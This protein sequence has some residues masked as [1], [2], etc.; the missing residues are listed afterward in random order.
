MAEDVEI[1][2]VG[3]LPKKVLIPLAVGLAGF[4][5][6]RFW[7]ARSGT[8]S[9]AG[10]ST[11][12]DGEF[13]AVDSSI[14]GVI[15][16]VSPTNSYG[17]GDSGNS[18]DGND[19]TRFTNN[20]QWT[21]YVVGK[22][23]QSETWSY[24]DIVTAIGL[25]LSG[26]PT[27]TAQQNI[28]R[29]ALAIGGQPPSGAITIVTGGNTSITVAPTGLA[30]SSVT[31]DSAWLKWNAVPGATSYRVY[32]NG[33]QDNVGTSNGTSFHV[34]GLNPN[35]SYTFTVKALSSSM[36]EGPASSS[37]SVK[38]V[39]K[40]LTAPAT[41]TINSALRTAAVAST[42]TVPNAERYRWYLNGSQIGTSDSP[43][44]HTIAPLTAG[45]TYSLAV[46]AEIANQPSG[47]MSGS[48]SFTTK[49]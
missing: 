31:T 6:W 48:R 30:A 2:K 36:Q 43:S 49:K 5:A 38:T 41:P 12:T 23:Q 27:T 37:V 13:G 11:I 32:R 42:S 9:D 7:Q 15:G 18:S 26:K 3:K 44:R 24:T 4:V 45:K 25:G 46:R 1:P 19:P 47:P 34:T 39:A 17:S 22:L 40:T 35:T 8:G 29:A 20:S 10:E 14:P 16:A 28:L 21:D 33:G